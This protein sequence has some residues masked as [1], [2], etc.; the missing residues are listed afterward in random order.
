[1]TTEDLHNPPCQRENMAELC[2][3]LSV[4]GKTEKLVWDKLYQLQ[5]YTVIWL[6][7]IRYGKQSRF[8]PV[9]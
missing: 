8:W 6:I 5:Q 2:S 7:F 9:K 4:L 3:L 1:M